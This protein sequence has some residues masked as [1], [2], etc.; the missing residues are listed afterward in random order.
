MA[1]EWEKWLKGTHPTVPVTFDQ[2]T[3]AENAKTLYLSVSHPLIR[4]AAQYLR[5][6]EPAYAMLKVQSEVV[7]SGEYGFG[8]Y[9]WTKQGVKQEEEL[10]AVVSDAVVEEKL[11]LLLQTATTREDSMVYP[12]IPNSTR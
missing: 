6:N 4:Q 7:I 8:I 9:R 12:I 10:V 11:F 5:L 1:K 2:E 3:A